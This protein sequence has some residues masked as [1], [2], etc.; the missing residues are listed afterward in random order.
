MRRIA[1]TAMICLGAGAWAQKIDRP[2]AYTTVQVNK[3][4]FHAVIA[5]M[6]GDKVTAEAVYRPKLTGLW[7]M[8]SDTQPV[9]SITGTFFAFENQ[10]PIADV[11]VD[12]EL[13]ATGRRGS[14]V[15]VDWFGQVKIFDAKFKQEIDWFPYRYALRGLVRVISDG[16][17]SPNPQAQQFKDKRIWGKAARTGIGLTK[18]NKLVMVATRSSVTLSELGE[19]MKKLG[20]I[21]A[22]ALDG[23]GSTSLYYRGDM[24][25]GTSRP[26]CNLFVLHE[27]SPVDTA[28]QK[29]IRKVAQA[30]ADSAVQGAFAP[31]VKPPSR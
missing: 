24:L 26:L 28:Y 17:V 5:D 10:K 1:V 23:G 11:L 31:P 3:S 16:K 9:A 15:A 22:V 19:A 29:H 20:A 12:G 30:Q 27:R 18:H 6:N 25:I 8:I 13:V 21:N 7:S 14:V 2:I 4:Y